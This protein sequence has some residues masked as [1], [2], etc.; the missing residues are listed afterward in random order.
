[1]TVARGLSAH[2]PRR[3]QGR[4][5]PGLVG[6]VGSSVHLWLKAPLLSRAGDAG[7]WGTKVSGLHAA[8]GR[9]GHVRAPRAAGVERLRT[10]CVSVLEKPRLCGRS[11]QRLPGAGRR[12]GARRSPEDLWSK[13]PARRAGARVSCPC[14]IRGMHPT[15][16]APARAPDLG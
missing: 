4:R 7:T 16:C 8:E 5:S 15:D 1:M 6:S 10:A 14:G 12:E 11:E 3:R 13:R 9:G 2:D